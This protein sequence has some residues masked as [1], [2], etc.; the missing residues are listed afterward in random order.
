MVTN[1]ELQPSVSLGFKQMMSLHFGVLGLIFFFFF[2]WPC[3]K[4]FY[5]SVETTFITKVQH[6][7]ECV[8][9]RDTAPANALDYLTAVS[10]Q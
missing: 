7:Y 4:I 1:Q 5:V 10:F 2:F 6:Q 9:S 8:W 3:F